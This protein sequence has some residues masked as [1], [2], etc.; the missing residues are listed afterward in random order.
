MHAPPLFTNTQ[1]DLVEGYC[2]SQVAP[3]YLCEMTS[4]LLAGMRLSALPHAQ[5][6]ITHLG[7]DSVL[8]C[9]PLKTPSKQTEK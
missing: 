7:A 3:S 5:K 4:R 2:K 9:F 6:C 8:T 1:A